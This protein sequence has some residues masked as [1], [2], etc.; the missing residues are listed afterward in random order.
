ME[1]SK[2]G[3][4]ATWIAML[5]GDRFNQPLVNLAGPGF[6]PRE[7]LR[8]VRLAYEHVRPSDDVH[9]EG[10][11]SS[12]PRDHAEQGRNVLLNAVLNTR[13]PE[14]WAAKLEMANDPLFAH[15]RDRA[16]ALATE[17]AAEEADAATPTESD[18]AQLERYRELS[19]MTRDDMFALLVDRLDDI[20]DLLL[21]DDSPREAWAGISDERVMRREIAREL[22][23]ASNH[24]YTVDQEGVT[25]DE[26]ETD[27]RLR[28]SA[29]DQQAV[30][31]LKLGDERTGRD[32]RDTV[33]NQLVRKYMAAEACRSGCLLVTISKSRTWQHPETGENLDAEGLLSMLQT[34]S[35]QVAAEMGHSVLLAA[36][37]LDLRPR[38]STETAKSAR[39]GMGA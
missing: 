36:K 13:G 4:G 11:H 34:E 25:A 14:G 2:L 37:V 31:E 24:A 1:P 29:S 3:A 32:L 10:M 12:G 22:R 20:D 33:R 28:S 19:P 17:R 15:F 21:R 6:T 38:L 8:L 27:I 39:T 30:I 9:H 5:F 35:Q 23:N 26:K 16:I 18:V 7:L